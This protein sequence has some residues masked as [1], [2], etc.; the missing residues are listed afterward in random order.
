MKIITFQDETYP[1]HL[2]QIYDYPKVLFVEGN[3]EILKEEGI[4]IIG[5][6]NSTKYG[7][8]T[9]MKLAY[10]LSINN[11]VIISGL[12]R[13]IDTAA[14]IGCLHAKGKTIAVLRKRNR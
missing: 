14:H 1:K 6:R 7:E 8:K 4:A 2:K 13:G 9:A 10:D 11:K 12:A 3:S 5:C